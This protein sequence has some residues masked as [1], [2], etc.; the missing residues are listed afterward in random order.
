M[1]Y[2]IVLI[3]GVLILVPVVALI[4]WVFTRVSE[5]ATMRGRSG[6]AW[7]FFALFFSPF[8]AWIALLCLGDTDAKRWEKVIEEEEWRQSIARKYV[9]MPPSYPKDE[10][11][12]MI[13][14]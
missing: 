6:T 5:A 4:V 9:T 13:N 1:D 11:S 2:S 3:L 7:V 14:E 10:T 12:K 8:G